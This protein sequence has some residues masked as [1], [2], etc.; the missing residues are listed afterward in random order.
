[1]LKQLQ[2]D[3]LGC[4]KISNIHEVTL[5]LFSFFCFFFL[6]SVHLLKINNRNTR[7]RC[8]TVKPQQRTKQE[9]RYRDVSAA[10]RRRGFSQDFS[11]KFGYSAIDRKV[12]LE[13]IVVRR[14][15]LKTIYWRISCLYKNLESLDWQYVKEPSNKVDKNAVVVLCTNSHCKEEVAGHVQEKSP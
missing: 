4:D 10:Q 7:K 12:C 11:R 9:P 3:P 14:K 8:E 1:M 15:S 6:L 13:T 5:I 2:E